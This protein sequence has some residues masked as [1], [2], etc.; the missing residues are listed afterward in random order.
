MNP[1][2]AVLQFFQPLL[3]GRVDRVAALALEEELAACRSANEWTRTDAKRWWTDHAA[4]QTLQF[5]KETVRDQ[6]TKTIFKSPAT[7]DNNFG[8]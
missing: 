7:E 2:E 6:V 3:R 4:G 1:A 8:P 5:D